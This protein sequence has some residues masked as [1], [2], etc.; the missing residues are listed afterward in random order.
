MGRPRIYIKRASFFVIG[1]SLVLSM[2]DW[3]YKF[4]LPNRLSGHLGRRSFKVAGSLSQ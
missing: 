3:L 1:H 2:I 4:D